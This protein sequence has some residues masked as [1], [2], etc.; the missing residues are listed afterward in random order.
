MN[1]EELKIIEEQIKNIENI[2]SK[3]GKFENSI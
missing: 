3:K 1:N 2:D